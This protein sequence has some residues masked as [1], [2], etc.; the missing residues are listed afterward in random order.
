M[1]EERKMIDI[2]C[3][4]WDVKS[5]LRTNQIL[6]SFFSCLQESVE[7]DSDTDSELEEISLDEPSAHAP[8]W[9]TAIASNE[10]TSGGHAHAC[11]NGGAS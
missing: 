7:H 11:C 3:Y 6:E 2:A 10:K 8:R 1:H 9:V 5:L 4:L